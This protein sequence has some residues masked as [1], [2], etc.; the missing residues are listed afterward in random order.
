MVTEALLGAGAGSWWAVGSNQACRDPS[1][2]LLTSGQRLRP[3]GQPYRGLRKWEAPSWALAIVGRSPALGV[4]AELREPEM[5]GP[6]LWATPS[7]V[8][9]PDSP[10]PSFHAQSRD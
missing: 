6:G 5:E 9:A 1:L 3:Q 2:A 4:I 7:P 8:L 10:V